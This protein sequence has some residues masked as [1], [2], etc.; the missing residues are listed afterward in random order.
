[1]KST[2][3]RW[4]S[5]PWYPIVFSAYPVLALMALQ[6]GTYRFSELRRKIGGVSERMLAHTLQQLEGDGMVDCIA[7]PVVPPHVE[8]RLTPLGQEGARRLQ[9]LAEWIEE[10]LP[11]VQK[12]WGAQG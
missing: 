8:Y 3:G 1:M 10:S 2:V 11:R 4:F 6:D 12:V 5:I 7:Y 9:G